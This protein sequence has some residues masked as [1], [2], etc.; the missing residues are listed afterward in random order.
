LCLFSP[1]IFLTFI[2]LLRAWFLS[3]EPVVCYFVEGSPG[4]VEELLILV[5]LVL[6]VSRRLVE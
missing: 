2:L 3:R 5:V 6:S 1:L 4:Y